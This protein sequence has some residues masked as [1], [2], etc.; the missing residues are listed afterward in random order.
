MT[1]AKLI[2][3]LMTQG[4]P[5][6]PVLV[7]YDGMI[8]RVTDARLIEGCVVLFHEDGYGSA[9]EW[10]DWTSAVQYKLKDLA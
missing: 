5:E 4:P 3:V 1:A 10:K 8:E 7:E 2:Q 6:A 9:P